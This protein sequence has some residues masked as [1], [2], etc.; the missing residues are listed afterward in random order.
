MGLLMAG[1]VVL[2]Y[3]GQSASNL[4]AT[5]RPQTTNESSAE[6]TFLRDSIQSARGNPQALIKSLEDFLERFPQSSRREVVLRTICHES[7]AANAPEITLKYGRRLLDLTPDDPTLLDILLDALGRTNDA[8]NR[9]LSIDYASRLIVIFENMRKRPA[10]PPGSPKAPDERWAAQLGSLYARRAACYR[11]SGVLEKALSDFQTSYDLQPSARTAEALGDV[12]SAQGD[13][14]RALDYYLTAFAFPQ[15]DPDLEH[16][17]EVRRKLG[18]A[19]VA[20]YGSSKGLGDLA[21]ARSDELMEQMAGRLSSSTSE[22]AGR[23]D[24]FDYVLKRTDGS[25]LR[26]ADYRG[27]ILVV[28]FWATWCGPCRVAGRFFDE[29]AQRF[30]TE[31]AAAF[32]A[33]NVDEDAS[34]VPEFLKAEGWTAPVAYGEGLDR[35]MGV[36]GLPTVVIFDRRGR[37]VLRQEGLSQQG[38]LENL[39]IRVRE[40][41]G[42]TGGSG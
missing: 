8:A 15:K 39:E 36:T 38:F 16:R 34:R 31:T 42:E 25:P 6:E 21:L 14:A 17:P 29:L 9:A 22:N 23:R 13:A 11:E 32:L 28:D 4:P 10:E 2:S 7:T 1:A 37:V 27:K 18:S 35:L 30:H 3:A 41:L 33:V 20:R 40:A 12:A 19:Y 5:P 24:P 26:M